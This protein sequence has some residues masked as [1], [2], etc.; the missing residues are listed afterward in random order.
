[1]PPLHA[2]IAAH[3]AA[4]RRQQ[5]ALLQAQATI[6]AKAIAVEATVENK[7]IQRVAA[8]DAKAIE[9]QTL[10]AEVGWAGIAMATVVLLLLRTAAC[11][12]RGSHASGGWR[13]CRNRRRRRRRPWAARPFG[14]ICCTSWFY[15]RRS[16]HCFVPAVWIQIHRS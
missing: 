10:R 2:T 16:K 13:H 14:S 6:E 5:H 1:M 8:V 9:L 7:D 3:E 12:G 11:R 15:L 4:L